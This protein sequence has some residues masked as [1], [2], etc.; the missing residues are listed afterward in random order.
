MANGRTMGSEDFSSRVGR[1]GY[2]VHWVSG[3]VVSP[4]CRSLT[5]WSISGNC[6][7]T[8]EIHF[9]QGPAALLWLRLEGEGHRMCPGVYGPEF[10]VVYLG[11]KPPVLSIG[12]GVVCACSSC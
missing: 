4:A 2:R 3:V 6:P 8:I 10:G 11:E 12:V 5:C 7:R 1:R 9:G